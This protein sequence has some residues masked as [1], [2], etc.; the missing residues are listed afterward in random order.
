MAKKC[1]TCKQAIGSN[2][3]TY[4]LAKP[5]CGNGCMTIYLSKLKK[6]QEKLA[7]KPKKPTSSSKKKS[8]GLLGKVFS[9]LD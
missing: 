1:T 3:I 2:G 4:Y 9:L 6:A 5:F 8:G 7:P